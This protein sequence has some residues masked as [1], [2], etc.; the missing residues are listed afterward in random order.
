MKNADLGFSS[1]QMR[2]LKKL[3]ENIN[4][5]IRVAK[6][7]LDN[8]HEMAGTLHKVIPEGESDN[9]TIEHV[10]AKV[11]DRKLM[12]ENLAATV[13]GRPDRVC[14][15]GRYTRLHVLVNNV[16]EIMMTDAP[17]ELHSSRPLMDNARGR[18]LIAGLGLGASL[19][20]VLRKKSVKMVVVVEKSQEVIDLV[21]PHI[22][23]V[24]AE[25]EN[26]KLAV[27]CH[28]AF[29]WTPSCI[30]EPQ[31][32]RKFDCI[33][34]DIWPRI[35]SENLPE[36]TKLKRLYGKWLNKKAKKHWMG[37]WEETYLRKEEARSR[38]V[39]KAIWGTVGGK[40]SMKNKK[41]TNDK[42]EEIRL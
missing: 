14:P 27:S 42:G 2:Q 29:T 24:L 8:K 20:P 16:W 26:N 31:P 13:N 30:W 23:K 36:I 10:E 38:A 32:Y 18:V 19:I 17:Y 34:L 7:L 21:L 3:H 5:Q 22:R 1:A 9:V 6:K 41:V 15:P 12:L 11:D 28:D 40:M 4:T 37:A 35:S 39:E 33:W 25:E